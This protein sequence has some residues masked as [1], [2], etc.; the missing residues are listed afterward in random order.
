[1][2]GMDINTSSGYEVKS[3]NYLQVNINGAVSPVFATIPATNGTWQRIYVTVEIPT[4]VETIA[5]QSMVF[6][7]YG[8]GGSAT[9]TV[10]QVRNYKFSLGTVDTGYTLSSLDTARLG[11][12][13]KGTVGG[14]NLVD[15]SNFA[16]ANSGI[17]KQ[18]GNGGYNYVCSTNSGLIVGRTYTVTM[19]VKSPRPEF[20]IGTWYQNGGVT[21]E[22]TQNHCEIITVGDGYQL[23]TITHTI[24]SESSGNT[25][26]DVALYNN[27]GASNTNVMWVSYTESS[28]PCSWSPSLN[29]MS[30]TNSSE[31]MAL[32]QST[33]ELM[34]QNS[35][36]QKQDMILGRSTAE[37]MLQNNTLA[38]ENKK[39][40]SSVTE[41]EMQNMMLGRNTSSILLENNQLK[42]Q[43]MA[44]GKQMVEIQLKLA[45]I[46]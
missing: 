8:Y 17:G 9:G 42:E 6:A 10:I 27:H 40:K 43:N 3:K 7:I 37:L 44:L 25:Y 5:N 4:K 18:C 20:H 31:L 14:I 32:G 36:A 12:M 30:L 38:N 23:A 19:L 33:T 22:F 21:V 28:S 35:K 46:K 24:P 2:F 34:L 39:L 11:N 41:L 45:S 16:M 15:K 13:I 26:Y 1:M 29:D